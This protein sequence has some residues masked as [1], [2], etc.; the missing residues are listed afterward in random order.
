MNIKRGFTLIELLM[1]AAIISLL[2][3][4]VF[5]RV[6]EAKRK[7]EDAHMRAESAEVAKAVYQYKED[8]GGKVPGALSVTHGRA[9]TEGST[10]YQTAMQELV[11]ND[12]LSE[13]PYSPSGSSYAYIIPTAGDGF[14]AVFA[15][16]L[17]YQYLNEGDESWWN[18]C[19]LT[20][21]DGEDEGGGEP[22]CT[23][24]E[25]PQDYYEVYG[26]VWDYFAAQDRNYPQVYLVYNTPQAP[27]NVTGSCGAYPNLINEQNYGPY[28]CLDLPSGLAQAQQI[29]DSLD[30]T[31]CS[32][33]GSAKAMLYRQSEVNEYTSWKQNYEE[34]Y[35]QALEEY[36]LC[37]V[38]HADEYDEDGYY[39]GGGDGGEEESENICDGLSDS[40]YCS[41]M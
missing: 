30:T 22:P 3:S 20:E 36:D 7:G 16:D 1:V 34:P 25:P 29:C 35:N 24:P 13:I 31:S 39:I 12:Y 28:D 23:E 4:M 37:L 8:H 21:D 41:C 10:E 33:L 14:E 6:T 26:Q 5:F 2:M 32:G 18:S 19:P 11:Y 40:D 17:N 9:H 27:T 38:E 15:A